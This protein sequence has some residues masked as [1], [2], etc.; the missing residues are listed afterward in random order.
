MGWI[1]VVKHR[2]GNYIYFHAW[3]DSTGFDCEGGGE[4]IYD[5]DANRFWN[6]ALT[7]SIRKDIMMTCRK[8]KLI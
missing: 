8:K 4:I 5:T 1:F 2:N 7:E 6:F 3:C